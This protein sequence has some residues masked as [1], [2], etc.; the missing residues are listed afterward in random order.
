MRCQ[1]CGA[2]LAPRALFCR[3]C[4]ERATIKRRFC[5]NCGAEISDS[6]KYCS[7]CGS[8]IEKELV[9]PDKIILESL[10]NNS[11]NSFS[12]ENE[13]EDLDLDEDDMFEDSFSEDADCLEDEMAD[14]PPS[15][16]ID[17]S[18]KTTLLPKISAKKS[19][20][21]AKVITLSLAGFV[22]L[23]ALC[24]VGK[25]A[26]SNDGAKSPKTATNEETQIKVA[27][28][29]GMPYSDALKTLQ[30]SGFVNIDAN[31]EKITD[32]ESWIVVS[33]SI[34]AGESVFAEDEIVLSC[35]VKCKLYIDLYSDT[36]LLFSTYDITVFFDGSEI[37]TVA[38][39]KEF[40]YLAD[41]FSG[42]HE[43][44]FC[45][46]GETTPSGKK[47]LVINGDTTYTC[48]LSHDSNSV[49]VKNDSRENGIKGTALEVAD[50]TGMVLSDAMSK[51]EQ[52]GFSNLRE[53]PYGSIWNRN[54][55]IV[56]KQSVS[57]GTITD[58]GEFIQLD[59]ISLD[60]YFSNTYVGKNV[61]DIQKS[62]DKDG[63]AIRFEDSSGS[64]LSSKIASMDESSKKR[65]IASAA[66][67]YG[68]AEKTA[69][70]T[71][72]GAETASKDSQSKSAENETK[73]T[74]PAKKEDPEVYYS[75]NDIKAVKNGN[76]GIYAYRNHGGSYY[77]YYVIDFDEGYVY[78]FT[79]GNDD[80]SCD[81]LR[82]DSGD[83]N[84]A[85]IVTY[86][87]GSNVWSNGLHFK[88]KNQPTH[89]ILEDSNHFEYDFYAT[90][91]TDALEIR[92][93][94]SIHDY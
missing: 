17:C 8:K 91:L 93:S 79:K 4:G 87:D 38:N 88:Y 62:A 45:K 77:I 58:K 28:V 56:T 53:E 54:N 86:H 13:L 2:E 69:V 32:E 92:D 35:A 39:G 81:R 29:V 3:E 68:G 33:Q 72:E 5:K 43:L 73:T 61:I 27:D 9:G 26:T 16:E 7:N 48:D 47:K 71:I 36:N 31:I 70:V 82:I 74:I 19:V 55:W 22:L 25:H 76:S 78:S 41:T 11:E 21:E 1:H 12:E 84:S 14:E 34:S 49:S 37:G 80:T 6:A 59:C 46:A 24:F 94:K 67:R 42:E 15:N 90:D 44:Y 52:I 64:D 51:L 57:D 50:V 30:D 66:R 83:L 89:M 60:D 23:I 85:L 40:T 63:F 18:N 20:T 10:Y 65:W 75:S